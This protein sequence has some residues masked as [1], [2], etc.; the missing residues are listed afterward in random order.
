MSVASIRLAPPSELAGIVKIPARFFVLES[1]ALAADVDRGRV[2]EQTVDDGGRGNLVTEDS[3]PLG[4]GLA[5][6]DD[7]AASGHR[8]GQ[9]R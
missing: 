1:V 3:T 9:A 5:R 7:D 2:V 4:V 6:G 8:V